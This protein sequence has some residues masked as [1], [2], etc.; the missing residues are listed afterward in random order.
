[1]KLFFLAAFLFSSLS[2]LTLVPFE[3]SM[4]AGLHYREK[5][6]LEKW[7]FVQSLY[8]AYRENFTLSDEYKIPKLI[9]LIWLGSFL[10]EKYYPI[11]ESWEKFHPDWT[12]KV[13]T[14]F[15]VVEFGL[16]NQ[17]AYNRAK[18]YGEKSD[19]L[20]Y[21][22][23][24]RFGGLYADT[25]FECLQPFDEV[26]RSCEFYLGVG[27]TYEPQL[28][29]G[30]MGSAPGHPIMKAAIEKIKVGPGDSKPTRILEETSVA[31]FTPRFFEAAPHCK[32]GTV[33]PFPITYFYP[34]PGAERERTDRENI[35]KEYAKPETMAIHYFDTSWIQ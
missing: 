30:L 8:D 5:R 22:L 29:V 3:E 6:E 25:D 11:V 4:N 20:R 26:H 10:P 9:H 13:W 15:D 32:I 18:N 14:D 2:S 23:L 12:V 31:Y 21:E 35:K 24:Y 19:I 7:D 28:W 17:E 1:M 34:F 16:I 33:V 27:Q